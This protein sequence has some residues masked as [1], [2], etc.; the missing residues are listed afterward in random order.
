MKAHRSSR[1][2]AAE[3]LNRLTSPSSSMSTGIFGGPTKARGPR[4]PRRDDRAHD[5][6]DPTVIVNPSARQKEI[7]EAVVQVPDAGSD[8]A[9]RPTGGH[10]RDTASTWARR[11]RHPPTGDH[12]PSKTTDPR[13]DPQT[14]HHTP[15]GEYWGTGRASSGPSRR[16]YLGHPTRRRRGYLVVGKTHPQSDGTHGESYRDS[17]RGQPNASASRRGGVKPPT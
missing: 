12:V 17:L 10:P 15:R 5:R 16:G 13:P 1:R 2:R 3:V 4:P 8:D 7:L 11:P 6:G 14:S 9:H